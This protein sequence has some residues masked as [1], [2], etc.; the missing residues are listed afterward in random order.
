MKDYYFKKTTHGISVTVKPLYLEEQSN[1][2][3]RYF[4]WAY[5]VQIENKSD[6]TIQLKSRY[7]QIIDSMG[8]IQEVEGEGVVGEQP[9]LKPGEVFEYSSGTP[10]TT[11]GG[12]MQGQYHIE[13]V[14]E[15]GPITQAPKAMNDNSEAWLAVDIPAF[16][17]DSPYQSQIIH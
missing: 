17:L 13:T 1:P 3:D 4:V 10:L 15:A 9:I 12:I 16:S 7:W 14:S 5:N 11:P 8:F 6:T 2:A